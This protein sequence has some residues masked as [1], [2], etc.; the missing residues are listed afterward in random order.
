M[1]NDQ[2]FTYPMTDNE[3]HLVVNFYAVV[4]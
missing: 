4:I 2:Y 3:D 1:F